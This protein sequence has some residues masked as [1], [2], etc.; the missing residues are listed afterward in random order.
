MNIILIELSFEIACQHFL[1]QRIL[2]G[3]LDQL[4]DQLETV[5]VVVLDWSV[6]VC[7]AV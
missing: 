5:L 6:C 3:C 2:S 4:V 1:S 7:I